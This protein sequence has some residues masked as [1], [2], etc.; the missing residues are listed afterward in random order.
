MV[1]AELAVALP[2]L[3]LLLGFGLGAVDAAVDKA[4]CV[5]AAREAA[6]VSAR[7]GDG[8]AAGRDQA[9]TGAAVSVSVGGDTVTAVVTLW[10]RPLGRHL[11]GIQVAGVAVAAIEP[12]VDQ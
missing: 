1:T 9:P 4:R 8:D 5:D 12:G 10:T 3:V 6:L 7:G 11:P 2:A